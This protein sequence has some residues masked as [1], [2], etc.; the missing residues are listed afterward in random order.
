M[1]A[2][3]GEAQGDAAGVAKVD[4]GLRAGGRRVCCRSSFRW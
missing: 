1:V 4:V 3:L 2:A